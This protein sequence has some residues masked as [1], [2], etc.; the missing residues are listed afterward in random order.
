MIFVRYYKDQKKNLNAGVL[1]EYSDI[2]YEH[3]LT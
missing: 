2:Q 3:I 1:K